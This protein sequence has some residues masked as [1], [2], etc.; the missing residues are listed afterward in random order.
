[1]IIIISCWHQHVF[2]PHTHTHT[3]GLATN[4]LNLVI[5]NFNLLYSISSLRW[6]NTVPLFVSP[7]T[8]QYVI[9]C[10]LFLVRVII[11]LSLHSSQMFYFWFSL[12]KLLRYQKLIMSAA[13]WMSLQRV[14]RENASLSPLNTQFF[15]TLFKIFAKKVKHKI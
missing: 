3:L 4:T 9:F 12:R 13:W 10:F 14:L 11:K 2:F 1:M 15:F 8:T 5:H 7:E 6:E